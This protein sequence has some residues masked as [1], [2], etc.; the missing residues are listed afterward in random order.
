MIRLIRQVNDSYSNWR[1]VTTGVA[2][3]PVVGGGF[4]FVEESE[5]IRVHSHLQR[6]PNCEDQSITLEDKV[7]FQRDLASC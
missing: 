1:L 4:F 2:Q 6:T 5:V 3:G 7:A